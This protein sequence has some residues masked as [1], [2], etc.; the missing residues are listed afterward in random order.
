[1]RY[2]V[3]YINIHMLK[4]YFKMITYCNIPDSIAIIFN[5]RLFLILVYV[6]I[7]LLTLLCIF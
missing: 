2:N 7:I 4:N 6:Y 5:K 3:T 1:M